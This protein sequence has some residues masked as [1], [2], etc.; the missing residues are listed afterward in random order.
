MV[1]NFASDN[2]QRIETYMSADAELRFQL[3]ILRMIVL[4]LQNKSP[5]NHTKTTLFSSANIAIAR[6][7]LL[8]KEI[9]H[10]GD[11]WRQRRNDGLR[12]RRQLSTRYGICHRYHNKRTA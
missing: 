9:E 8:V 5:P 4:F 6:Y 1:S 7:R 10:G 2:E 11:E 3:E 12:R